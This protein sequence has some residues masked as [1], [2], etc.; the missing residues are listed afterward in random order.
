[1]ASF[2]D[3]ALSALRRCGHKVGEVQSTV[4]RSKRNGGSCSNPDGE[5]GET[6]K[7]FCVCAGNDNNE[8][9]SLTDLKKEGATRNRPRAFSHALHFQPRL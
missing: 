1:M 5:E 2:S 9:A 6:S 3:N 8:S 4:H 7:E